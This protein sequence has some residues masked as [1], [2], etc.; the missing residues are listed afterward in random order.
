MIKDKYFQQIKEKINQFSQGKDWKFFVYG[1]SLGKDHFGDVDLGVM[2]DAADSKISELKEEFEDSSLPY[3]I[4]LVNFN[5]VS[6]SFKD[7]VFNNK[8]LWIKH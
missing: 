4:D 7:N 1:S 8:I 5:K 3:F 6:A 2:G